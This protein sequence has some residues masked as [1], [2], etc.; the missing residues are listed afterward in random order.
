MDPEDS[1]LLF[2]APAILLYSEQDSTSRFSKFSVSL[3]KA[4]KLY[5]SKKSIRRTL[6]LFCLW[7]IEQICQ[8]S[9]IGLRNI[10]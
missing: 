2:K 10:Q 4:I 9:K 5:V 7:F 8:N 1:L 3:R 6:C